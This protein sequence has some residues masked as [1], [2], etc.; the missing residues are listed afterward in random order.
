MKSATS[1][2]NGKSMRSWS[3]SGYKMN[4]VFEGRSMGVMK[5]TDTFSAIVNPTGIF[6]GKVTPA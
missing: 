5:G 3:F 2:S 1:V 6:F 4:E